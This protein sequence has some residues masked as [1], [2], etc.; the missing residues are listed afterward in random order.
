MTFEAGALIVPAGE[1]E[2]RWSRGTLTTIKASSADTGGAWTLLEITAAP[3]GGAEPHVHRH[4]DEAVY[5]LEGQLDVRCGPRSWTAGPGDFA[6]LPSGI[7]HAYR[8][9]GEA[10]CRLLM[11]VSPGGFDDYL[12]RVSTPAEA[13]E[14]PPADLDVGGGEDATAIASAFGIEVDASLP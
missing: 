8:V 7:P 1:G 3:G 4:S 9:A 10:P 11:M 5:V 6:L 14:L 12:S 2:H 13:A